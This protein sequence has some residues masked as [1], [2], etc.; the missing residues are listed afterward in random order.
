MTSLWKPI[1]EFI[2]RLNGRGS[3]PG[4]HHYTSVRGALGILESGR[5]WFT[6]RAHL[7]DHSEVS[8]GVEIAKAILRDQNRKDD[9]DHLAAGAQN[10]FRDFRFFSGS[11]SLEGNDLHQWRNYADDGRGVVLSF[12]A[13]SFNNPKAHIDNFIPDNPTALVCPMSY[14]SDELRSVIALI[15]EAWDGK[16][17]GELCDHVFMISSMFKSDCWKSENEYRFF[18][19]GIGKSILKSSCYRSRERN[20]EIVSCLDIPIQNWRSADDFPIYRICLGPA[21]SPD[22]DVQ[23]TDFLFSKGIRSSVVKSTLPYR[24]GHKI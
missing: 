20:G 23:L 5:L 21:A 16:N 10:V 12:K 9:A 19:H 6:E 22:L 3:M 24:S 7:N 18:V 11:F 8:H 2:A 1:E 15:I 14:S 4:V 17:V 13:S